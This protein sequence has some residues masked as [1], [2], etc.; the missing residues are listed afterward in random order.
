MPYIHLVDSALIYCH[1][2]QCECFSEVLGEVL[3]CC[4]PHVVT[5]AC[6]LVHNLLLA[7]PET[8]GVHIL[9]H[10]TIGT[11]IRYTYIR[12]L[13][14]SAQISWYCCQCCMC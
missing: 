12:A 1:T 7:F 4:D 6:I 9:T 10:S 13:S 8:L 5:G 3:R 14:F 2:L 11:L